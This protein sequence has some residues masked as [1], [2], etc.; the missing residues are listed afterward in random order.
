MVVCCSKPV[1]RRS[2]LASHLRISSSVPPTFNR[3][4]TIFGHGGAQIQ[5]P[6][7]SSPVELEVWWTSLQFILTGVDA[8]MRIVATPSKHRGKCWMTQLTGCDSTSAEDAHFDGA[9]PSRPGR[10]RCPQRPGSLEG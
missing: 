5:A 1:R 9:H 2:L 8:L 4:S 10:H 6:L 7:R 3:G